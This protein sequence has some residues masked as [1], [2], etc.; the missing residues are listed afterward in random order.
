[1]N[2]STIVTISSQGQLTLPKVMREHMQLQ[3]QVEL[4]EYSTHIGIYRITDQPNGLAGCLKKYTKGNK[5][6]RNLV[7]KEKHSK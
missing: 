7:L 4:V 2:E 3:G 5:I 6:D 1:M